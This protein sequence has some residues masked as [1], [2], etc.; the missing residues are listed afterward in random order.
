[1]TAQLPNTKTLM[2]AES[3]KTLKLAPESRPPPLEDVL[4][5]AGTTWPKA[6][7]ILG[8]FFKTRKDWLIR[9]IRMTATSVPTIPLV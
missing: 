8:N 7:K 4:I 3:Q 5:H 6:G 9:I 2:N 1:M